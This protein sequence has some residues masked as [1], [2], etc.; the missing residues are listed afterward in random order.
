MT[1]VDFTKI[2]GPIKPMHAVNNGP[3]YKFGEQQRL[4][5]ID[6]YRDAGIPYA[7]THDAAFCSTYGGEHTVDIQAIFPDFGA[8]PYNPE[9]YDFDV[10]DYYLN[11][12]E[13]GGAKVFYRLGSKIEHGVKKYGT[14]PPPDF[15]KWAVICEH[16][17]RHYTEGWANGFHM[18]IEYWEIW[19]EADL[20]SGTDKDKT[21]WG[22]TEAEFF[23]LFEI[24]AKHL[25]KC[26]PQ[27][28][29]G[30]PALSYPA[31][32]WNQ[33]GVRFL[34]HMSKKQVPMDFIS[35][36]VY[37]TEAYNMTELLY[38]MKELID[39]Y[40]YANSEFILNEWNYVYGWVGEEYLRSMKTIYSLKGA[41]FTA[42][43]MLA[44]QHTPLDMLMYYDARPC[45]FNGMFK[46][47]TYELLKGY[48]PFWMFNKL[49][50]LKNE[51]EAVSEDKCIYICAANSGKSKAVML[52]HYIDEIP[53]DYERVKKVPLK[54]TG[55]KGEKTKIKIY[56]LDEVH[57]AEII[58]E[59]MTE[60][61]SVTLYLDMP[62]YT[63]YLVELENC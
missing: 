35:W 39:K 14:L 61:N 34:E 5:N 30:G 19:N 24:A 33:W 12:I 47:Y 45:G 15:K 41:A 18:D 32:K 38:E 11:V 21:T 25:K 31:G 48:Y 62:L 44:M 3:I 59:E 37:G 52:T 13:E 22:G 9:S 56:C 6:A 49:Y 29:I 58:R 60:L 16:I 46:P 55:L 40:G 20:H 50:K 2:I 51:V 36:H 10:T 17:I 8:D 63:T 23:D 4:T 7:R 53:Q 28:K 54:L 57:N 26:F 42:S 1:A 43:V 27:L